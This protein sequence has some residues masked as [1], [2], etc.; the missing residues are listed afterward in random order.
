MWIPTLAL[1]VLAAGP[2]PAP[3]TAPPAA[4]APAGDHGK[5]PWFEGT[6]DQLLAK[7]KAENKPVFIDFWAEW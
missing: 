7:A 5:L 4:N 6:F 1:A 3:A 2:A